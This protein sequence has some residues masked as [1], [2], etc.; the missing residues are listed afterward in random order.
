[1]Q[2]GASINRKLHLFNI[3]SYATWEFFSSVIKT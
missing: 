3:G 1:M 2:H